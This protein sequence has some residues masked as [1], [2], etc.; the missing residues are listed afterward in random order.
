MNSLK[1]YAYSKGSSKAII[2]LQTY[3]NK[4]VTWED[5][6]KDSNKIA[7][8]MEKNECKRIAIIL[9]NCCEWISIFLATIKSGSIAIPINPRKEFEDI[10][11]ELDIAECDTIFA[12]WNI[13]DKICNIYR[14]KMLVTVHTKEKIS[15]FSYEEIVSEKTIIKDLNKSDLN[16][17]ACIYFSSG[18]TGKAKAVVLTLH[19][20]VISGMNEVINHRQTEKDVFLCAAPLHHIGALI[21]WLGSFFTGG[22]TIMYEIKTPKKTIEIIANNKISIA[23]MLLPWVQDIISAIENGDLR[24]EEYNLSLWRLMHMGAQPI[25]YGLIEKWKRYFPFQQFDINYGLTESTGP[26]CIHV[27]IDRMP[28]ESELGIPGVGW[29]VG[30]YSNGVIA[31]VP[32]VVGEIVLKGPTL[33]KEYYNDLASTNRVLCDGWLFTGDL[34]YLDFEGRVYYAGRKKDIIIVGGENIY[35][36]EIENYIK[37]FYA[38]KDVAVIGI[39]DIRLGEI[40]V[41]IVELKEYYNDNILLKQIKEYCRK[42][43]L[44]KRP[45]RVYCDVLPRNAV[46]KIDK[47]I[48]CSK[49]SK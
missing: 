41:A 11:Q 17:E 36:V 44:Y 45:M 47:K 33:M 28:K 30:I 31:E 5:L 22:L 14:N 42:L 48:L 34:G 12:D 9:N 24:L 38:V 23:W 49:Y 26:G 10:R 40:I 29:T 39:S 2:D 20:L 1:R 3:P 6:Y 35:P 43:P 27:G 25:P 18:T 46:G 21:H 19:S 15:H 37:S 16:N 8:F 13:V 7:Y 32:N 4:V